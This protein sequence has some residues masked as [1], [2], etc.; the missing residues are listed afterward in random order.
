M[1]KLIAFATLTTLAVSAGLY[2][3]AGGG[4]KVMMLPIETQG[5]AQ[6]CVESTHK[7]Q[8]NLPVISRNKNFICYQDDSQTEEGAYVS[9]TTAKQAVEALGGKITLHSNGEYK[10]TLAGGWTTLSLK[11]RR[12]QE[13]YVYASRLLNSLIDL[14]PHTTEQQIMLR[15]FQRPELTVGELTLKFN[16]DVKVPLGR[17]LYGEVASLA[18]SQLVYPQ[19]EDGYSF[20]QAYD[21]FGDVDHTVKTSLKAGEVILILAKQAENKFKTVLAPVGQGGTLTFKYLPGELRFVTSA[22]D[23]KPVASGQ[24]QPVILV[25]L[26]NVPLQRI[27]QG[28]FLPN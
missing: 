6:K 11:F 25:R 22:S 15:G 2:A 10:L 13:P 18:I 4:G 17:N 27:Q 28:I 3:F 24:P 14:Q 26:S 5:P 16:Q 1:P 19:R 7:D 9:M 23:L 21:V 8:P 12:G 20:E